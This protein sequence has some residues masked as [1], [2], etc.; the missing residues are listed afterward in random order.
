MK[1]NSN[2]EGRPCSHHMNPHCLFCFV[3]FIFS[4]CFVATH[5]AIATSTIVIQINPNK[6]AKYI[7]IHAKTVV[8][9]VTSY[10][11]LV[12]GGFISPKNYY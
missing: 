6:L 3:C 1:T 8:T 9:H 10:Y 12:G 4:P 2:F 5:L 11:I 7:A